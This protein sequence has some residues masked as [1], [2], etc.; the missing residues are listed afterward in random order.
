[1]RH[2]GVLSHHVVR[3][4]EHG[5]H[6]AVHLPHGVMHGRSIDHKQYSNILTFGF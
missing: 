2:E 5:V 4:G 3:I 1:M 6:H